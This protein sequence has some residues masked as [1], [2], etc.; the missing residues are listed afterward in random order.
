MVRD[1]CAVVFFAVVCSSIYAW[2]EPLTDSGAS[3]YSVSSYPRMKSESLFSPSVALR[4]SEI[5]Y[6]YLNSP[7]TTGPQT[8]QAIILLSA[9]Q[10]LDPGAGY[11]EPMLIRLACRQSQQDYS[12]QIIR[13]LETYVSESAELETTKEAVRYLLEHL[14]S[15][16]EREEL[17]YNLA[18]K[19]GGRNKFFDSELEMLLAQLMLEK[20]DSGAA[21]SYFIRAYNDNRYNKAAFAK[22]IEL[23]PDEVDPPI[24]LEHLRLALR[25]NPLDIE[26]ALNFA[27]YTERL[28]LYD[29]SA[30]AYQYCAELFDYLYP[31]RPLPVDIYLPWAL[32]C[33]NTQRGR[34]ICLQIA[35]RVRS[36][37]RFDILLEAVAG[38]AAEKTGNSQEA[39]RIFRAAEDK[40][41]KLLELGP[42]RGRPSVADSNDITRGQLGAKQ[43]AWFYSFAL[44]DA[45]KALDWANKA[46]SMEPDSPAAASILA[47]AL[48]LNNQLEWAKPLIIGSEDNQITDLVRAQI[49]ISEGQKDEAVDILRRAITKDPASLA[50]DRAKEILTQ[51][52]AEYTPPV[53]SG[54]VTAIMANNIGKTVVPQFVSPDKVI[55]VQ[56]NIQGNKF[57]YG[58]KIGGVVAIINN[59]A[60]PLVI[61][62][63]GL[64]R[65]GIRVDARVGGDVKKDLPNLISR[66]I[67]SGLTI[68]PGRSALSSVGLVT[69]E[70][71]QILLNYPQASLDIEF[72]LYLDP[73]VTSQGVVS[74]RLTDIKPVKVAVTRPGIELSGAYLRTRFNSISTGQEGQKIKTAQLFVGL[75]R[76]QYAMGEHGTLYPFKYADW[77]PDLLKSALIHESGLLLNPADG[78]WVIKVNTM[79]EMISMPLDHELAGALAKNLN[80]AYWPVRLMAIYVLSDSSDAGFSNVLNWMAQ[81][82]TN[83]LV[84]KMALALATKQQSSPAG[85]VSL[86]PIGSQ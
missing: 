53:D 33:Y 85:E 36:Q 56:F 63:D 54:V 41:Q 34:H 60:E 82:D 25:E 46:Y 44:V 11:V 50:A 14:N 52:G 40:A 57:S 74:N 37:G 30:A 84:R 8:E 26:A 86:P 6:E 31:G 78:D 4:F 47:Y 65:G 32:S 43:F 79:A 48:L 10:S 28:E 29:I 73:V 5:G 61:S 66:K 19:L 18:K 9:A 15:R 83:E 77:M 55:S 17:L 20:G 3:G 12:A 62:D 59:S 80:N 35:E 24:V 27:G 23:A 51:Q 45:N 68:S 75:L 67:Y 70:L 64:F 16:E 39:N 69:G 21:K 13:W 49:R 76:E 2:A 71:K 1:R 38:K 81:Y 58:S 42:K 72:T 22:L 7:R